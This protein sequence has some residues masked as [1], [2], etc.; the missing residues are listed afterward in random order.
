M[1]VGCAFRPTADGACVT[2]VTQIT[3]DGPVVSQR[4]V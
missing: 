2:A 4:M 1:A 3:T